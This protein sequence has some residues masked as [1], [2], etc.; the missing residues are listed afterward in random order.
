MAGGG[1]RAERPG[2]AG[3][4]SPEQGCSTTLWAATSRLLQD[5]PGV[6]CEDCDIA[7]PTDPDNPMARYRGVDPHACDDEA[8]E[9]LWGISEKLL[10][11][12]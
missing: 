5:K 12:A 6:Y 7:M 1:W 2:E 11:Q 3:F 10:A 9:R 4:K 8:A